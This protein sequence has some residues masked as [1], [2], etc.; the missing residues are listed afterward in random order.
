MHRTVAGIYYPQVAYIAM[1]GD[2]GS[3][4]EYLGLPTYYHLG[5]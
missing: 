5:R 3:I 4:W 2:A 1:A